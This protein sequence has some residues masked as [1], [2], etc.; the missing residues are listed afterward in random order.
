MENPWR[1]RAYTLFILGNEFWFVVIYCW[2]RMGWFCETRW[3][4]ALNC[5]CYITHCIMKKFINHSLNLSNFSNQPG[6][7]DLLDYRCS[8]MPS[9][10]KFELLSQDDELKHQGRLIIQ[11]IIGLTDVEV[12]LQVDSSDT[13]PIFSQRFVRDLQLMT[14]KRSRLVIVTIATVATIAGASTY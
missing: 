10:C 3:R 4:V 5:T 12:S 1:V 2:M 13:G 11:L 8:N 7:D 6:G 9:K 14:N